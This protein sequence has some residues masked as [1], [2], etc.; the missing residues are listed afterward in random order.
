MEKAK[1]NKELE[2]AVPAMEAA[3]EAVDCLDKKSIQ[4]L[5]SLANPPAP[6]LDVTKGV[7]LLRGEK[8]NF[9]WANA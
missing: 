8:K 3:K 1:A 5:K 9:A 4:E 2:E 7:L 6:V